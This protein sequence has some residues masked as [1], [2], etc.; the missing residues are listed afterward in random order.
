[1]STYIYIYTITPIPFSGLKTTENSKRLDFF[2]DALRT[3]RKTYYYVRLM[4][5]YPRSA[6]LR[7]VL[8]SRR[9]DSTHTRATR[10]TSRYYCHC[11]TYVTRSRDHCVSTISHSRR[12][13]AVVSP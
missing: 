5:D 9:S 6:G 7:V 3:Q 8:L 13:S 2:S 4:M 1:M 10:D 11:R 12:Q